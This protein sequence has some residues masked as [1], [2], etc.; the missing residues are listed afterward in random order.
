MRT[1]REY[2]EQLRQYL[3]KI[4]NSEKE[5][6]VN[7]YLEY[8]IDAGFTT[9]EQMEK[10]FGSPKNLAAV[11]YSEAAIKEL[12]VDDKKKGS[13]IKALWIGLIALF[14]LPMAFPFVIAS[15]A[16][17]FAFGVSFMA[18]FF[19]LIIAIGSL[20]ITAVALF[21]K[22]FSFLVPFY[23]SLWLKSFGGSIALAA[24]V[25]L[26]LIAIF[27]AIKFISKTIVVI[28]SKVVKRRANHD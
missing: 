9:Y 11:I 3:S 4:S 16:I 24:I 13:S 5:E 15:G 2:C 21:I 23:P 27:F 6:A 25:I 18:I 14:S 1:Y 10:N 12:E 19:A 17:L 26:S 28:I 20:G 8:A 7:Y 22:S